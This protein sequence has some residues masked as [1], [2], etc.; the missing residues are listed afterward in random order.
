MATTYQEHRG[1][2]AALQIALGRLRPD[3]TPA[4]RDAAIDE[5][6]HQVDAL[7]TVLLH[8]LGAPTDRYP[9]AA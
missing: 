3:A 5:A 7:A 2:V 1:N 6:E 4:E 9:A 8:R